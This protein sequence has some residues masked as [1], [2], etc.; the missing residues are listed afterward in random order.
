MST[1][2]NL[3]ADSN[4]DIVISNDDGK[5][6]IHTNGDISISTIAPIKLI[7]ETLGKFDEI[8]SDGGNPQPVIAALLT[9]GWSKR[10]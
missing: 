5:I 2:I 9:R 1:N 6:T 10:I 4:G 7:G 3:K 8:W